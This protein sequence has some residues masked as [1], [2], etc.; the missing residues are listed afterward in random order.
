MRVTARAAFAFSHTV[1]Q[2][3]TSEFFRIGV[4]KMLKR[5][6]VALV[7]SFLL[8]SL[9]GCGGET[10]DDD[11]SGS[12]D[13]DATQKTETSDEP[14][15]DDAEED[16]GE[17]D[18]DGR[19]AGDEPDRD[20][21]NETDSSQMGS[22]N[23]QVLDADGF[24][25]AGAEVNLDDE[26]AAT[27]SMGRASLPDIPYSESHTV[28]VR[29]DDYAPSARKIQHSQNGSS[30]Q[31]RLAS[32]SETENIDPSTDSVLSFGAH[33]IEIP[34]NSLTYSNGDDVTEQIVGRV[35]GLDS[36]GARRVRPGPINVIEKRE[37]E[38]QRVSQVMMT[39]IQLV[40]AQS[41]KPVQIKQSEKA[42]LN[43]ELPE[44]LAANYEAGTSVPAG[45]FDLETAQ[46]E[47]QAMGQMVEG[48]SNQLIWKAA[49][50]H[51]SWWNA[52][53]PWENQTCLRVQVTQQDSDTAL[54]GA[55]VAAQAAEGLAYAEGV[56]SEDGTVCLV[57]QPDKT[58]NVTVSHDSY[59]EQTTRPA[60]IETT[61]NAEQCTAGSSCDQLSVGMTQGTCIRGRVLN[62][63]ET[64]AESTGVV[65]SVVEGSHRGEVSQT[66]TNAEGEYCM[67]VPRGQ[68]IGLKGFPQEG[69]ATEMNSVQSPS[70][71]GV[72]TCEA[73]RSDC[74]QVEPILLSN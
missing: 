24:P 50:E 36:S 21:D 44:Q 32:T 39:S 5:K 23:I 8:V 15:E 16:R 35:S 52:F 55:R 51:F 31:L 40:G 53:I 6:I 63:D 34:A 3:D 11:P 43:Y 17:D 62:A 47:E 19:D 1:H 2:Y 4:A 61:S 69:E 59:V 42:Q 27:N 56:T 74:K 57:V 45:W 33:S 66:E 12:A 28:I 65:G 13:S 26:S 54:A 18:I 41:G 58:F 30:V 70:D 73:S 67:Q 72:L 64:P 46:W 20:S 25:V 9:A 68:Q 22:L 49:V 7:V 14:S 38:Q 48:S 71:G 60:E 29:A 10:A 37:N